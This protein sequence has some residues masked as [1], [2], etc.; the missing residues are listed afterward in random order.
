MGEV[1]ANTCGKCGA[2]NTAEAKFCSQ[3]GAPLKREDK[4]APRTGD[5]NKSAVSN[6]YIV[7]GIAFLFALVIIMLIYKSNSEQLSQK[8][9]KAGSAQ[10]QQAQTG[11]G[12]PSMEM[13]KQIQELKDRWKANPTDFDLNVQ[14]GNAYFD[15]GRFNRSISFYR[16]ANK[17]NGNQ[18]DILI[19]MGVAYFN[20]TKA[21]SAL[22][23]IEKAL[24]ADPNH[25]LG[26]FNAGIIYYNL[27]RPADA[28]RLWKRLIL[29]YAG[30]REAKAAQ[31]YIKQV[32]S[33]QNKS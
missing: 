31:E 23:F 30:T 10:Q 15:I 2:R 11:E 12:Q 29:K 7:L 14:L 32:E 20:L 3:C 28:I 27:N 1:I 21:D 6:S 19:D 8:I 9:A 4:K 22:Y 16:N 25:K 17:V 24:Q 13:M 18:P 5:K 33:E 26:L